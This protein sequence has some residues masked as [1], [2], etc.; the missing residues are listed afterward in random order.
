MPGLLKTIVP[1]ENNSADVILLTDEHYRTQAN[2]LVLIEALSDA[3]L[4]LESMPMPARRTWLSR[5]GNA[6]Q[7]HLRCLLFPRRSQSH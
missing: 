4:Q 3:Q 5:M 2:S 6:T 7:K 1:M